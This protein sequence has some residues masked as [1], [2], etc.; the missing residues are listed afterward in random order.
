MAEAP[1]L[2][3]LLRGRSNRL[4]EFIEA[5]PLERKS[6]Y[7]FVDEQ[8]RLLP[9]GTRVIDIGAGDAPYRELFGG[10]RYVT[11]DRADT[12]HSGEVDMHGYADSIPVEDG[13]FDVVLCTQVLE[14]VA[15]PLDALRE[16][17]RVL[18]SGGIMIA[19]VA[20]VWEER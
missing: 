12:P 5:A 16:F 13:S 18:R 4:R 11:L 3:A 6:I 9:P 1:D 14:H 20:F 19:T 7:R 17:R 8:A 15:Q 10:Q 2:T